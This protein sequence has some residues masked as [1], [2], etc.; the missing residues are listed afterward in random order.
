MKRKIS[1]NTFKFSKR[2]FGK[3]LFTLD[4]FCA[5]FFLS[6]KKIETDR[7]GENQTSQQQVVQ[8][9][10]RPLNTI[11]RNLNKIP[12]FASIEEFNLFSDSLSLLA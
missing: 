8:T 3:Q 11:G 7:S 2:K 4:T 12:V 1:P 9:A 6:C 5:I 10:G